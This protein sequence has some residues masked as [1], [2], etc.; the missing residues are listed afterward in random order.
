MAYSS[1]L[2]TSKSAASGWKKGWLLERVADAAL[3]PSRLLLLVLRRTRLALRKEQAERAKTAARQPT[4]GPCRAANV[5]M[6]L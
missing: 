4:H 5:Q 2:T 6:R 3:S 1:A